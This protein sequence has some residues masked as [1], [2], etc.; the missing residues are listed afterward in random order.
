MKELEG[1]IVEKVF[2]DDKQHTLVFETNTGEQIAYGTDGDCCS[3]TWFADMIGIDAIFGYHH[4]RL[5]LRT[6]NRVEEITMDFYNTDDGRCRQD[7]DAAYG[8][9]LTTNLGRL[10]IAFRNS[11]NGY[12]GG[13]IFLIQGLVDTSKMKQITQDWHA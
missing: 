12:Y 5:D 10:L 4:K 7:S 8:Y 6:I 9:K 1:K 11:S 13:N 3:E 2:V